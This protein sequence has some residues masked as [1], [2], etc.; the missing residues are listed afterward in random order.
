M[1]GTLDLK[2]ESISLA[3]RSSAVVAATGAASR[4][5]GVDPQAVRSPPAWARAA[6]RSCATNAS[7]A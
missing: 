3:P 7:T 2:P 5:P 1:G 4:S 6:N